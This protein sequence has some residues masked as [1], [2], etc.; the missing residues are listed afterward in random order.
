[1][2]RKIVYQSIQYHLSLSMNENHYFLHESVY[3]K[4]NRFQIRRIYSSI[5]PF[6]TM[7]KSTNFFQFWFQ[8]IYI[9]SST[10]SKQW[11]NYQRIKINMKRNKCIHMISLFIPNNKFIPQR[12]SGYWTIAI[13]YELLT[14][15]SKLESWKS[16][17]VL[18]YILQ[19]HSQ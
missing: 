17:H 1:M 4:L 10:F 11:S 13:I 18:W 2:F 16:K 12:N 3:A 7:K 15:I 6:I 19:W 8:T 14:N 5:T 9:N